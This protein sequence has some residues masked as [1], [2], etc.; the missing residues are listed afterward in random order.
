MKNTHTSNKNET[1]VL[2][3]FQ[4]N[5]D[6]SFDYKQISTLL[7]IDDIIG[8]N[9]VIKYLDNLRFNKIIEKVSKGSYKLR[10][11][12]KIKEFGI[13][14]I[15]SSGKG[16][17]KNENYDE[18]LIERKQTNTALNGDEVVVSIYNKKGKK[19]GVV[20]KIL[21]RHKTEFVGTLDKNKDY[22][23]VLTKNSRM[24]TDFFIEFKE[25]EK[26]KHGDKVLVELK[27][28]DKGKESPTGRIIKSLG[29]PGDPSTEIHAILHDYD[30]PY[31]FSK[32][33]E[34]AAEKIDKKISNTEISKRRDFRSELTFTIDPVSAKDFDDALSFREKENN[35][36]EIG[37][38]IADVSHYVKENSILE[39]EAFKRATSV[40]LV[41]RVVPML[42]EVLSNKLCSL[43]PNEE[44]YC[45]SS[46]FEINE[47]GEAIKE[48]YGK[49]IIKSN[50]RFSYEEVQEVIETN[51]KNISSKNS[52]NG[53][54]YIIDDDVFKSIKM[55][56]IIAKNLRIKRMNSGA[57][58]FDRVEVAF[59]LNKKNFPE[60]IY[61]KTSKD[62]H[63]LIEEFMLLANKKVAEYM[64]KK[65]K[66]FVYRV[67]DCPDNEKLKN[68]KSTVYKFGYKLNIEPEK[69]SYSLNNLLNQCN[70]KKE[71]NLIDTLTLRCMSR[72]EYTTK[73]IGH[74][75][76][77][78]NHYTHFTSPIRRYP[79]ILVHRLL[80]A[81]LNNEGTIKE[82]KI[83]DSCFH[84]SQQEQLATKAE[85]ASIKFM[86][87]IF[88][89]DKV[90]KLYDGVIS[91]V[92]DRGLYV[93]LIENKCEGMIRVSDIKG[94]YFIY[95]QKTHSLIGD[96]T[97]K[98][99]MLGQQVK[100]K[101][102]K[103]NVLKSYLDF[104]LI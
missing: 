64:S 44:K 38:H 79:D 70:G 42:P 46:V 58:S 37:I 53:K 33:L 99:Y 6:K 32:E 61:F 45:F 98:E 13:I 7:D 84:S 92:T 26:Y 52:L 3:I 11:I 23:F 24:H 102:K 72:A 78:F 104:I 65:L 22:G 75:G 51:S 59:K 57:I 16:I 28:W 101:V 88:M 76:L 93:E 35:I 100:I 67:H 56:N 43:R 21:K 50:H 19:T 96:R 89:E 9:K 34:L 68:L 20:E 91:G 14:H 15:N 18:L 41:D 62:A 40:Y 29:K 39:E 8:K 94:D 4:S 30:L 85:R 27:E 83:E 103:V 12:N 86:Q 69:V 10:L 74:Y 87:V 47:K 73:N 63:K 81:C 66:S 60:S 2:H 31:E 77:A 54:K 1:D 55:L 97:K 49:T 36:Y 17:F 25:Q 82:Y 80:N 5:S 90:G 95:N 71:Q 48:W